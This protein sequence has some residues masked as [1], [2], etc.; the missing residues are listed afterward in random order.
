MY[1]IQSWFYVGKF[2]ETLDYNLLYRNQIS[3]MLQ[4]AESVD[5]QN[6]PEKNIFKLI[7]RQKLSANLLP[8]ISRRLAVLLVLSA[9]IAYIRSSTGIPSKDNPSFKV[10]AV[11]SHITSRDVLTGSSDQSTGHCSKN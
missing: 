10:R 2:R 5:Q 3:A 7:R 6:N 4:V 9:V 1:T 11:R 8:T